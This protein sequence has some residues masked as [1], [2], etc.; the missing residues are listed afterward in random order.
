MHEQYINV[1]FHLVNCWASICPIS[2]LRTISI[3]VNLLI[4]SVLELT[5][6]IHSNTI[7]AYGAGYSGFESGTNLVNPFQ[8][9]L[10]ANCCKR[11]K[12]RKNSRKGYDC[13]CTN[14]G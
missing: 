9:V 8:K 2:I 13:D 11:K 6:S 5:H 7:L 4:L 10:A 3:E 1:S 12:K 14:V